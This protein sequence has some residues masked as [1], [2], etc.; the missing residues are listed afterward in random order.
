VGQVRI[1]IRLDQTTREKLEE[2]RKRK[3]FLTI[4]ETVRYVLSEFFEK[5]R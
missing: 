3:G 1:T 4:S 5:V 2:L